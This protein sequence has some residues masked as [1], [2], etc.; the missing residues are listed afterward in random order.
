MEAVYTN[1]GGQA[2]WLACMEAP[3]DAIPNAWIGM[4]FHR[5]TSVID[6]NLHPAPQL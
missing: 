1:L 4:I 2:P 3:P 5:I 6:Q